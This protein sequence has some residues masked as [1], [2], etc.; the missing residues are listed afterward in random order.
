MP[1]QKKPPK[2]RLREIA[3]IIEDVDRRCMVADGPVTP[4]R[5]EIT[6]SEL[7]RIYKLARGK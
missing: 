6:D 4:T 1:R 5:R 2:V 7:R 3:K